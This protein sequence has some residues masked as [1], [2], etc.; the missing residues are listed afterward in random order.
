MK[1]RR[2]KAKPL[3]MTSRRKNAKVAGLFFVFLVIFISPLLAK[4][5]TKI[6]PLSLKEAIKIALNSNPQIISA[7][8]KVKVA[9]GQL[10]ES[11]AVILPTIK[12]EYSL[13]RNYSDP[14]IMH[15]EGFPEDVAIGYRDS[16]NIYKTS[17]TLSEIFFGGQTLPALQ[18]A[19]NNFKAVREDV[20]TA[21]QSVIYNVAE[22]YYNCRKAQAFLELSRETKTLALTHLNQVKIMLKTGAATQAD[23]LQAA[24]KLAEAEQNLI[25]AENSEELGLAVLNNILGRP[26][27]SPLILESAEKNDFVRI[28]E[29]NLNFPFLFQKALKVRPDWLSLKYREKVLQENV[30]LALAGYWPQLFGNLAYTWQ[31]SRLPDNRTSYVKSWQAL[32]GVRINLFDAGVTPA[33][34]LEARA[35]L[36]DFQAQLEATQRGIDLEIKQAVLNFLVSRKQIL[37]ANQRV[38]LA[39]E[40]LRIANWRFKVKAGTSLEV[41]TAQTNLTQAKT[42]LI[43]AEFDYRLS[44]LKIKKAIGEPLEG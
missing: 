29:E 30:S 3:M 12:G 26:L 19:W 20:R 38:E 34:V 41:L 7:K 2:Q 36:E 18:I 22:A 21:E 9:Q 28:K 11:Y 27:E 25:A 31:D 4:N 1:I 15:I 42:A 17:L 33:K 16:Y 13:S 10:A 44:V 23:F 8:S 35:S 32:A 14:T 37:S 40:N 6:T 39:R 5:E 24:V 43:Q